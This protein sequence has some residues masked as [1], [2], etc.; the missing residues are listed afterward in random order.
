M[1]EIAEG[2]DIKYT[3]LIEAKQTLQAKSFAEGI[4]FTR[5]AMINDDLS[6]FSIIPNRFVLD[7]NTQR[8]DI[9]WALITSN[10]TMND[11]K[12]LFHAD[13]AN[14]ASAAGVISATTLKAAILAMKS[15][16]AL[17]GKKILRILPRFIIVSP[18]YEVDASMLI[19]SITPTKT[20]D[21]NVFSAMNLQV[22]VEP[23]L[24]GKAWY[25]AAD[26]NAVDGLYHCYLDGNEGLRSNREEDFDSDSIKFA[27][28]GEFGANAI[29]YRGLFK[30][31]GQ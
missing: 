16:K 25:L 21:I 4:K 8:G 6:A 27:V 9:I 14:L 22:L 17:D 1:K 15:Q 29:D 3:S 30:N 10:V 5:Q 23:R 24:S 20:A 26:P 18:E 2:E 19:T 13:H 12:T 11:T 28:R 31:N 7:W